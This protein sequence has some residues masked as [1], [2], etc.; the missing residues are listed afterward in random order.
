MLAGRLRAARATFWMV[1]VCSTLARATERVFSWLAWIAVVLWILGLLAP[2]MTEMESI[3]F[4]IGKT[5]VSL[6]G[7]VQGVLSSGLLL[8][9]AVAVKDALGAQGSFVAIDA[10]YADLRAF[11]G[12]FG[13]SSVS[14]FASTIAAKRC[15]TP[16]TTRRWMVTA[17]G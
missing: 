11:H 6:L 9:V 16:P 3:R 7:I 2:V 8:V 15:P 13:I 17:A 4:S 14:V 12:G 5:K 1:W 10:T